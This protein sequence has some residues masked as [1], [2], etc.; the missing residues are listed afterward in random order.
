MKNMQTK[1]IRSSLILALLL[2]VAG[3]SQNLFAHSPLF[4]CFDNGDDT[5]TCE[6]AFSDGSSAS[7]VGIR[8]EL[9]NGRVLM[10][11]ELDHASSYTFD[12]PQQEYSVFFEAGEG[13][14]LV[15]SGDEIY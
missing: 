10:Q 3:F 14:E 2:V 15:L 13:H 1:T 5:A 7:G 4:D 12:I 6:G 11:G 8:V 9:A